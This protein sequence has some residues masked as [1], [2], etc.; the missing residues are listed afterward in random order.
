MSN[1]FLITISV[2]E[3]AMDSDDEEAMIDLA[4]ERSMKGCVYNY[5]NLAV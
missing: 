2:K 5:N 3:I 1:I 4:I